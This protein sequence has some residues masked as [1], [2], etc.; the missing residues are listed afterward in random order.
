MLLVAVAQRQARGKRRLVK[1]R[2]ASGKGGRTAV[3]CQHESHAGIPQG[4]QRVPERS[5]SLRTFLKQ[6]SAIA[7]SKQPIMTTSKVACKAHNVLCAGPPSW[8]ATALLCLVQCWSWYVT[9]VGEYAVGIACACK[10]R[11][12]CTSY[13]QTLTVATRA[14]TPCKHH[15]VRRETRMLVASDQYLNLSVRT[16]IRTQIGP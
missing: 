9:P 8:W 14:A 6:T 16:Q 10:P 11:R 4:S 13:Q 12:A 15:V 3:S 2:G 5:A 7:P 1:I